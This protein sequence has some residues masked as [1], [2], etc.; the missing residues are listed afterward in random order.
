M[1]IQLT[2]RIGGSSMKY[3]LFF[4][5]LADEI[6]LNMGK[7]KRALLTI[8]ILS[9]PL[10]ASAALVPALASIGRAFPDWQRW[11][12]YLITIPPL[13]MMVS[14]LLTNPLLGR[15]STKNL[16][17]FSVTLITFSGLTPFFVE[18]FLYLLITRVLMGLG[19]GILN[20]IVSSF[21]ATYFESGK[22]RDMATGLQA[23]FISVGAMF[24]SL[25]S[26]WLATKSW[27]SVFLVQLINIIPLF[28]VMF[29]MPES[30]KTVVEKKTSKKQ[31][32]VKEALPIALLSFICIVIT[33][34]YPLNLSL[35]TENN[36]LGN[37]N[38]VGMLA[39]LNS[40]IGFLMG[41]V[42]SKM[43]ILFKRFT[44]PL[45]LIIAG[46]GF[47]LVSIASSGMALLAGS[48]LF[49]IGTS[50]ISPALFARLYEKV[51]S[52]LVI[53]A[54]GMLSVGSNLSQF[55]SPFV[56]NPIAN[57]FGEGE[58]IRYLLA[59][60]LTM[61]IAFLLTVSDIRKPK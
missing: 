4:K 43:I 16:T 7:S 52:H 11:L 12:Q 2:S 30:S 10:S 3:V 9:I 60:A 59:G 28:I 41:L 18:S 45:G 29:L 36:G 17:T 46:T 55:V 54:V 34:T 1:E 42:F 15:F 38:F 19:L 24:F 26:G 50:V 31:I 13:A 35:F 14:S 8:C 20:T 44:L 51:P 40:V 5:A 32:F 33:C 25:F 49:G 6:R 57:L 56:I 22:E 48:M 53:P 21:P 37:S 61:G 39:S 58:A 23:A 27:Q 47:F